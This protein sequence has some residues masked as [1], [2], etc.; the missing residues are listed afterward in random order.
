[1]LTSRSFCR[2]G[3]ILLQ[4]A[5]SLSGSAN[6]RSWGWGLPP[7]QHAKSWRKPEL[8]WAACVLAYRTW[9]IHK[10]FVRC[11]VFAVCCIQY[12]ARHTVQCRLALQRQWPSHYR[13]PAT[14]CT[15]IVW[16][17]MATDHYRFILRA[18]RLL[19]LDIVSDGWM[20]NY[21]ALVEW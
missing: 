21:A 2:S 20:H 1:M 17:S 16:L 8:M 6:G 10:Y 13:N 15:Q 9:K 11:M 7:P 3:S 18:C 19:G 4:Y 5:S 12:T 14:Y